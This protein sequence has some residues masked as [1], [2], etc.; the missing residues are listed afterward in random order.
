MELSSYGSSLVIFLQLLAS[1]RLGLHLTLLQAA[2]PGLCLLLFFLSPGLLGACLHAGAEGSI[3]EKF[4]AEDAEGSNSKD[5]CGSD[6]VLENLIRDVKSKHVRKHFF[7]N[8]PEAYT[9][10]KDVRILV[11][12]GI[13]DHGG[14]KKFCL[15]A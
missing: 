8:P 3:E 14:G 12:I 7:S 13:M 15:G 9:E 4:N 2:G 11:S 10:T 1:F 6:P 5:E